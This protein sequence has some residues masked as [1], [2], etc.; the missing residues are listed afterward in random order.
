MPMCKSL[1][2]PVFLFKTKCKIKEKSLLYIFFY[3]MIKVK[4][5][6]QFLCTDLDLLN[7][8][9]YHDNMHHVTCSYDLDIETYLCQ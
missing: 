5:T 2:T 7:Q 6:C 1:N 8:I 9:G 4:R 3:L